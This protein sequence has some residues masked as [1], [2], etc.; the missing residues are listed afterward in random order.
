MSKNLNAC[1]KLCLARTR[2]SGWIEHIHQSSPPSSQGVTLLATPSCLADRSIFFSQILCVHLEKEPLLP[3]SGWYQGVGTLQIL[4]PPTPAPPASSTTKNLSRSIA[5]SI[6]PEGT[7][8]V[9]E[10]RSGRIQGQIFASPWQ[11]F[12]QEDKFYLLFQVSLEL[13]FQPLSVEDSLSA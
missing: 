7:N 13:C 9:R 3:R 5:M 2:K 6:L 8:V 10:V 11:V 1:A 4:L 12:L